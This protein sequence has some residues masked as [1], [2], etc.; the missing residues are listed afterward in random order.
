MIKAYIVNFEVN[1]PR[2]SLMDSYDANAFMDEMTYHEYDTLKANG[3]VDISTRDVIT[4]LFDQN[5]LT[6]AKQMARDVIRKRAT[7]L[8]ESTE[9]KL[10]CYRNMYRALG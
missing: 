5:H 2:I 10:S 1:P 9:L 8:K 7:D 3:I 6:E 4:I